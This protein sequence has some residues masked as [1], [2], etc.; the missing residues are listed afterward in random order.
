MTIP[1]AKVVGSNKPAGSMRL[2]VNR[3]APPSNLMN[4][5][6]LMLTATLGA[7]S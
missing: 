3:N 7:V 4:S 5:Q 2:P 6:R 1:I